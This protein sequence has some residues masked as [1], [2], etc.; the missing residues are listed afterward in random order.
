MLVEFSYHQLS[1]DIAS[2]LVLFPNRNVRS[3]LAHRNKNRKAQN[4]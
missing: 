2:L 3:Q 1:G 4:A